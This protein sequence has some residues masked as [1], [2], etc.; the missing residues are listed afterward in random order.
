MVGIIS[1][2][3][4]FTGKSLSQRSLEMR[5][6]GPGV[7]MTWMDS[8]ISVD[9]VLFPEGVIYRGQQRYSRLS[10][11]SRLMSIS[12]QRHSDVIGPAIIGRF[13]KYIFQT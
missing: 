1:A 8:I 3:F 7:K 2:G 11:A 4:W 13:K 6:Q 9:H 10:N 5:G 12:Q